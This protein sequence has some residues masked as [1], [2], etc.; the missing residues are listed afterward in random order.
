MIS[1]KLK[2]E[3]TDL[4]MDGGYRRSRDDMWGFVVRQYDKKSVLVYWHDDNDYA[5]LR[6]QASRMEQLLSETGYIVSRLDSDDTQLVVT[7]PRN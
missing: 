6:T 1:A 2:D 3:I 4:L 5:P 7:K